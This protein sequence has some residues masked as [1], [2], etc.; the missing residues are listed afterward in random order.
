MRHFLFAFLLLP[1]SLFSQTLCENGYAG[2]YPC[3]NVDLLAH[4]PP[5]T[6]GGASTNEVWGWTDALDGKEYVLLGMS[7]GVGFFDIS[8]PTQPIYLGRLPTFTNNSLWRTL[9]PY[10]NFLFVGSE[11]SGHGLQVFD[12]TKLRS[13]ENPPV[14][15]S[16]DAHYSQFGKCHSLVIDENEGYLYAC[17]TN[18]FSGGLH[19]VNIQNPL[20]PVTA[21]GYDGSGYTHE[22]MVQLYN[23]P[24]EDYIGHTIAFCFNG[25]AP[26]LFIVADVTDPSDITLIS[27]SAYPSPAYCHQGCLTPDG[28]Y[29]LMDD[30]LDEQNFGLTATRTL[31]WDMHD[32]DAPLFMGVHNG[33]T[34]AIDHNQYIIG[35]LSYQ[36]NYTAGL[37]ILDVTNIADTTLNQVAYFDHYPLSNAATFDSEWMNYPYFSSGVLPLS[38]IYN[39]MFLVQPNFIKVTS[40]NTICANEQA[41]VQIILQ[42]GFVGPYTITFNGLPE[43]A[44]ANYDILNAFAPDTIDVVISAAINFSE[45]L[46][47]SITVNGLYNNYTRPVAINVQPLQA[48]Y[49]DADNDGFGDA[50]SI[51]MSCSQPENYTTTSTDCDD[52]DANTYPN[53][54]GTQSNTD[55]NCNNIIDPTEMSF[56]ADLD[57]DLIITIND[58]YIIIGEME[59]TGNN[60]IGDLNNDLVV[61]ITDFLLVLSNFGTVCNE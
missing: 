6:I 47:F 53:A 14:I 51:V 29:L 54:P 35:N 19:V 20:N 55:N 2:A 34:A 61:D 28:G 23:G 22:A 7:T 57:G 46:N 43:G 11:A 41:H 58:M 37:Q 32:L 3:E 26:T 60:C 49:N 4:I 13:V 52:T 17:G 59:C 30:E 10:N 9:R 15:F 21:G 8:T 25:S 45:N 36:S 12:L 48:W 44:I 56:C 18:S 16:E 50:N 33:S 27:S 42:Q 39:G 24:D 1:F 31:I 38:D 5:E 40:D